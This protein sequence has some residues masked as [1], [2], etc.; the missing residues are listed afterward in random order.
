M[1]D[2]KNLRD[3]ISLFLLEVIAGIV[4][5]IAYE[6]AKDIFTNPYGPYIFIAILWGG[7]LVGGGLW[8]KGRLQKRT[9]QKV[10]EEYK[11]IIEEHLQEEAI[12]NEEINSLRVQIVRLK[13]Q[14]H[15]S[16]V[17][18]TG[19][20]HDFI[21]LARDILIR[22]MGD[23]LEEFKAQRKRD[24]IV[25]QLL[26]KEIERLLQLVEQVFHLVVPEV[27]IYVSIRERKGNE[28]HTK[29][30]GGHFNQLRIETSVPLKSESKMVKAL[31]ESFRH[32][33][34]VFITGPNDPENWEKMHN[35]KF[36]ND[37]SVMMGAV[38]AKVLLK[39]G[40]TKARNLEWILCIC[41]DKENTF[42]ESHKNLMKCFN[43]TF[44][45]L[46]NVFLRHPSNGHN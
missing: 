40:T 41:A 13:E 33:D 4:A 35:D 2:H 28:F 30:R 36:G 18:R 24:S 34:C 38:F 25:P 44:A 37:R 20:H 7:F 19:L 8:Y 21:H 12:L 14:H 23:I 32:N 26:G 15:D 9:R 31:M 42:N 11:K 10:E 1:G 16:F 45:L 5:I 43:D 6:H 39:D 27:G 22:H 17:R 3:T 29:F 46:V